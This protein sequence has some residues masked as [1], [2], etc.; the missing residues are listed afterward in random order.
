MADGA[1]TLVFET[2][3]YA[4]EFD[5]D[6]DQLTIRCKTCE[7]RSYHPADV[8]KRFCGHCHRVHPPEIERDG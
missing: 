2:A 5:A 6:A 7:Q 4:I 1:M 3:A 8:E